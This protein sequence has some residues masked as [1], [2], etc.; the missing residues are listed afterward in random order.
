MHPLSQTI[1]DVVARLVRNAPLSPEKVAFAWRA[2]VG[3]AMARAA[4]LHL[5]DAG[6]VEVT[7]SDDHWRREIRRSLPVIKERLGALLG[8]DV[9]RRLKVPA[10]R[11]DAA[12]R[13]RG[14]ER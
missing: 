6:D 10:R 8:A 12:S 1:P 13:R 3:P 14:A 5:S 9:V 7:C 11:T 2:A 4:S